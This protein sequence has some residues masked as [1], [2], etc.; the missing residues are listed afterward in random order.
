MESCYLNSLK[1]AE[2]LG[3]KSIAFP[4]IST[5]I[6]GYPKKEAATIAYNAVNDFLEK[7]FDIEVRF[8]FHNHDDEEEFM[9]AI[10]Q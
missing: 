9:K 5:G 7:G 3:C 10:K 4:A 8:I 6:Y 1:T 2:E